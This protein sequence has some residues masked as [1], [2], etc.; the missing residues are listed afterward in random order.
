MDRPNR[1]LPAPEDAPAALTSRQVLA[2][3]AAAFAASFVLVASGPGRF[4]VQAGL[5]M[6]LHELGHALV[7]W[8]GGRVA[9]PIPLITLSLSRDRSWPL[10]AAVTAGLTFLL[11]RAWEED[12]AAF[13]AACA[14]ALLLQAKLTLFTTPDALDFWVAFG[15]LGGECCVAALLVALYFAR[16]PGFT[17]WPAYRTLFL[18]IGACV[19]WSSL[20]RWREASADFEKVPFGSFFGGDGDVEVMLAGGWTVNA[21]AAH[22]LRL[23][24]TCVAACALAWAWAA[25]GF[26]SPRRPPAELLD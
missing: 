10:A 26:M 3:P 12:C 14:A 16:W 17:R 2:V 11:R 24:W 13:G 6:Q 19:L 21:L 1:R 5:S 15:G 20:R 22:Y 25:R 7:C 23:S 8:L 4:F 9:I 18:F